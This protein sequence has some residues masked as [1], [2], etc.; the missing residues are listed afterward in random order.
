MRIGDLA[1]T[2]Q[3]GMAGGLKTGG[4]NLSPGKRGRRVRLLRLAYFFL[5]LPLRA[6]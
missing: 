1:R 6:A 4:V 5:P 2:H 3:P